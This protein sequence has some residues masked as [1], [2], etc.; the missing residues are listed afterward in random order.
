MNTMEA[1]KTIKLIAGEYSPQEAREILYNLLSSKIEFHSKKD[2]SSQD[3]FGKPNLDSRKRIE[4]LREAKEEMLV[5]M[6]E[7][8]AENKRI[9]I[10]SEVFISF[11]D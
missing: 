4:E 9:K 3:R 6:Q 5:L 1:T 11:E 8:L 2:F 7:A 10:S